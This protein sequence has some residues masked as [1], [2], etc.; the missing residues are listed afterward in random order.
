MAACPRR[1]EN[2]AFQRELAGLSERYSQ[3]CLELNRAEQSSGER[4][5]EISRK[6]RDMEQLTKENQVSPGGGGRKSQTAS[7]PIVW[8]LYFKNPSTLQDLKARLKEEMGRAQAAAVGDQR[9]EDAKDGASCELQ[10]MKQ[11]WTERNPATKKKITF[12]A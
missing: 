6:E 7:S 10:V 8:V 1:A 11:L 4:E 5:R 3:K 12:L 9:S 2:R